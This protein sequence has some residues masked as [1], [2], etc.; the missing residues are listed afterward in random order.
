MKFQASV[1]GTLV[2]FKHTPGA[3]WAEVYLGAQDYD[4]KPLVLTAFQG[5][6]TSF[7]MMPIGTFIE[8]KVSCSSR[9]WEKQQP[10]GSVSV[11]YFPNMTIDTMQIIMGPQG[12]GQQPQP[13]QGQ[14]NPLNSPPPQHTEYV[15]QQAAP[16]T[17]QQPQQQQ[18]ISEKL[19][20]ECPF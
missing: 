4:D 6:I 11:R 20:E 5:V 9:K 2:A 12:G 14:G 17:F 7:A 3:K 16:A 18:S 13:Q 15:G 10:D 1:K 8:V 19:G